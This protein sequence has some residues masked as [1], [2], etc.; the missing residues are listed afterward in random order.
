MDLNNNMEWYVF[1]A[2]EKKGP[3]S[4]E[5]L[6]AWKNDG[7]LTDDTPVWR[8][9]FP[10]WRRLGDTFEAPSIDEFFKVIQPE[11]KG[12]PKN[13]NEIIDQKFKYRLISLIIVVFVLL[14]PLLIIFPMAFIANVVISIILGSVIHDRFPPKCPFCH[15]R[16]KSNGRPIVGQSWKHSC[17]RCNI[18]Y[19]TK[20]RMPHPDEGDRHSF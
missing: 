5:Q 3:F 6:M 10:N 9:G 16:M 12:I 13:S 19:D 11:S 2:N 15:R 4:E 17:Y 1:Y 18:I 14:L 20:H 7:Y 8:E